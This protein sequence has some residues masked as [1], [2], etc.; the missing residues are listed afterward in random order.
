MPRSH[1]LESCN[2]NYHA[3]GF[4]SQRNPL[5]AQRKAVTK[6][7]QSTAQ[8]HS[9]YDSKVMLKILQVSLQQSMNCELPDVPAGFRKVRGSG[10]Q[11]TNSCWIIKK[12]RVPENCL[13]LLY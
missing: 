11:I 12:G 1:L 10:D 13:L 7:V 4:Q 5:Q 9:S 3:D 6:N 8:L 2:Y